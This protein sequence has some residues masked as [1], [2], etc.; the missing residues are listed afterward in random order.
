MSGLTRSRESAQRRAG[1]RH[2]ERCEQRPVPGPQLRA[3]IA[4]LS[5]QDAELAA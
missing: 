2:E 3:L 1:Q 4:G 5:L